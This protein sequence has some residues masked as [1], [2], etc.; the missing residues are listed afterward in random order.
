M[1]K[2]IRIFENGARENRADE[3][4]L[5]QGAYTEG[6]VP[7]HLEGV[8]WILEDMDNPSPELQAILDQEEIERQRDWA[9]EMRDQLNLATTTEEEVSLLREYLNLQPEA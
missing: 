6:N 4:D 8:P 9:Q 1:A 2:W 5:G 3:F 7:E